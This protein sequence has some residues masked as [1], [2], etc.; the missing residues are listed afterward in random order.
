MHS[1]FLDKRR[2]H[3][4]LQPNQVD[5]VLPEH[6]GTSYPKF[7]Q[8]LKY[9]YE[10]Q[11]E[12][13]STELLSHMFATRD[14]TET[15]ITLLSYIEDELLLGDSYFESFAEGDAQKRAAAN[16]SNTL[17]RSKGTKFAIQWFFRSFFGIDV[18]IVETQEQVFK[19]NDT[20]SGIGSNSIR[21]LTDDKLYQTFAY[22]IRSSV[23]IVKW[24]DLFKLFVHPAG[25]YLGGELLVS[26]RVF[27]SMIAPQLVGKA[28]PIDQFY[29]QVIQIAN[30]NST[31]PTEFYQWGETIAPD[32]YRLLT[33]SLSGDSVKSI[34]ALIYARIAAGAATREQE[35]RW[36]NTV[37]PSLQ[38]QPWYRENYQLY[39][40]TEGV[41]NR[42]K[43]SVYATYVEPSITENEGTEFRVRLVGEHVPGRAGSYEYYIDKNTTN[44]ADFEYGTALPDSNNRQLITMANDSASLYIKTFADSDESESAESFTVH[45]FDDEHRNVAS[46][47]ITINDV[48]ASYTLT[49]SSTSIDEGDSVQFTIAGIGVPNGG[50]TTLQYQV[51]PTA[52]DSADSADFVAT[53]WTSDFTP[54]DIR[55]DS[56]RFSV[57]TKVDGDQDSEETF[58]VKLYTGSNILKATSPLI[59]LNN[60]TPAFVVTSDAGSLTITEGDNVVVELEV[61]AT[62][63]GTTVNYTIGGTDPRIIT[64]TGSFVITSAKSQYILSATETS[65]VFE[66]V[67]SG[68]TLNLT[69][70]SGGFFNPELSETIVLLV[71]NQTQSF[72]ITPSVV[73]AQNG[74]NLNFNITGTNIQD[75]VRAGYFIDHVTTTDADFSTPPPTDSASALPITFTS[76]SGTAPFI[77]ANNGDSDNEDF[78]F[79]LTNTSGD[80]QGRL[81]YT[82][83]GDYAYTMTTPNGGNA[84]EGQTIESIFT[85]SAADGLYYY[86]IAGTVDSNDFSDG[87]ASI[88]A[89]QSFIVAGNNGLIDLTL[90]NDQRRETNETFR[91]YVSDTPSGATL[92]STGDITLYDTSVPLYTMTVP[93]GVVIEGQT[94][95][96]TVNPSINNNGS[97]NVYVNF[98]TI[99][100]DSADIIT[101]QPIAQPISDQ[102]VVFSTPIG[103]KDSAT[104]GLTVQA[105]AH[106]G[107]YTGT[108]V[109]SGSI[110][111]AD[112]ASS[113]TLATNA[114]DDSASEG[115]T[116]QFSF[117]GTN[118]PTATYYYNVSDVKPKA[119]TSTTFSG[120]QV[121]YVPQSNLTLG[122][123][124][125]GTIPYPTGTVITSFGSGNL[126]YVSNANTLPVNAPAGTSVYFALPEV[127]ADF[128]ASSN[129]PFGEFSHTTSSV[130]QFNVDIATDGDLPQPRIENYTMNVASSFGASAVKTKAFTIGDMTISNIPEVQIPPLLTNPQTHFDIGSN[131]NPGSITLDVNPVGDLRVNGYAAELAGLP[132]IDYGDWVDDIGV[133]FVAGDFEIKATLVSSIGTNAGSPGDFGVWDDLDITRSWNVESGPAPSGGSVSVSEEISF[134]IR[135]KANTSNAVTFVQTLAVST[136]DIAPITPF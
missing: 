20:Q 105:T 13:R 75:G 79:V 47:S 132:T 94:L 131:S 125:R 57:Q 59:T 19:L 25:M 31:T 7:I 22:L 76:N 54:I 133:D 14:I 128:G 109:T 6:F 118:V 46:Q 62:T 81:A 111:V 134:T 126:V 116:I 66:T 114:T 48:D 43:N 95:S 52:L 86:Y 38:D 78:F 1:N 80:E 110:V 74:D 36:F 4:R 112:A 122:M 42:R 29:L 68:V 130:S 50:S 97:E 63:V 56:G 21:F 3:L 90:N 64:K 35:E 55:N 70:S 8:L 26:D 115:D 103:V 61:D 28:L 39:S 67:G 101:P 83:I 34:D 65:D 41:V 87:W 117:N 58:I 104:G 72:I 71:E 32:G 30:G 89:R 17:F 136:I 77:L 49:P 44:I 135:E 93:T 5:N 127:W 88:N 23:P 100:G 73:G 106:V 129:K 108:L 37:L 82:I 24:K 12:E 45:F 113:Y 119:T 18:E 102:A 85:T 99:S 15:D 96:I 124:I 120:S 10:F 53:T 69:T 107:S 27:A 16:F 98:K 123:E 60:V 9:Y 91:I 92:A 40:T 33:P 2:R 51:I 84:N 11:T 121:L